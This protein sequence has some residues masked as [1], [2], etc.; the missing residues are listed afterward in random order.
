M[1][2]VFSAFFSLRFRSSQCNIAIPAHRLD[3]AYDFVFT[4]AKRCSR[5][6]ADHDCINIS[7]ALGGAVQVF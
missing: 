5:L 6:A 4:W 3:Q 1:K 2:G 7:G